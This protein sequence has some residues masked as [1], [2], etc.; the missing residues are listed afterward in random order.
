MGYF[1]FDF[2][3]CIVVALDAP[4]PRLVSFF[5]F[6]FI[7]LYLRFHVFHSVSMSSFSV[8]TL[9]L[10]PRPFELVLQLPRPV[11]VPLHAGL[12]VAAGLELLG[13]AAGGLLD[14]LFLLLLVSGSLHR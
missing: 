14:L 9:P 3:G 7:P 12:V 4:G 11:V 13:V 2:I 1:L 5:Q 8:L 6:L 10:L